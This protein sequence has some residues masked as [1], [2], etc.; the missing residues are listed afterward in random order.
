[1]RHCDVFNRSFVGWTHL[2]ASARLVAPICDMRRA[3]MA[4]F[5]LE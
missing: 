1:M 3:M 4:G 2:G 5:A